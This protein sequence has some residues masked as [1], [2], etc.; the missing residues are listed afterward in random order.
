MSVPGVTT[1]ASVVRVGV[2]ISG[3]QAL[4]HQGRHSFHGLAALAHH[5]EDDVAGRAAL[6]HAPDDLADR[7]ELHVLGLVGIGV[8]P[9]DGVGRDHELHGHP[10]PTPPAASMGVS[11]R[12]SSTSGQS[13]MEPISPVWPPPSVPWAMTMSTSAALWRVAWLADPHSAAT[14]LPFWWAFSITS[15]GGV[16]SALA[17]RTTFSRASAMS[18]WGPAMAVP[19][20]PE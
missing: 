2:V 8:A 14:S 10:L 15:G 12:T 6:L 5:V 1:R 16:P 20:L 13:T 4:V 11:P 18:A 3:L 19:D 17:S 9:L 7:V